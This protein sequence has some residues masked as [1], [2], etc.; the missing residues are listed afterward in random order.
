ML[1]QSSVKKSTSNLHG[2]PTSLTNK[3]LYWL[4]GTVHYFRKKQASL[5]QLHLMQ[6]SSVVEFNKV[7]TQFEEKPAVNFRFYFV[8]SIVVIAVYKADAA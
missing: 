7:G 3:C 2:L 4:A 8:Y 6:P 5:I 1:I